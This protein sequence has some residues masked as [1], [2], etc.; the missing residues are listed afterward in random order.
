M[1]LSMKYETNIKMECNEFNVFLIGKRVNRV[2]EDDNI[3]RKYK[4]QSHNLFI[5]FTKVSC[6]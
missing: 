2:H 3:Y 6:L 5:V 4:E 1:D